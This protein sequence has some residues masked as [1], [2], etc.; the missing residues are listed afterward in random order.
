MKYVYS[1]DEGN[2]D[3]KELL[4]GKGANLS[5]MK[6]MKIPVPPGFIITTKACEI[7]YKNKKRLPEE[8]KKEIKRHLNELEK[9]TGKEFGDRKNPLLVSVRSG[10]PVS[11]PGMLDTIL[12]IGLNDETVEGLAKAMRNERMALDS[13]KRLIQTYASTVFGIEDSEFQEIIEEI[14]RGKKVKRIGA[15]DIESLREIIER[16]KRLI[17]KEKGEFPQNVEEQLW[18]A[19]NAVFN[20]WNNER[21]IHYRKTNKIKDAIGTAVIIQ[22]IVFG[23]LERDSATGVYF[24][25]NPA[26]GKNEPFGEYI[27]NA[28]GDELVGGKKTPENIKKLKEKMP[29]VFKQLVSIGKK[30][31]NHYKDMQDI[32]FTIEKGKL[33]ILQTRSGKRTALAEVNIAVDL[34]KE[35]LIEKEEALLRVKADSL[36]GLLHKKLKEEDKALHKAIAKGLPASIGAATGEIAFDSKEAK[37]MKEKGKDV[38]LVRTETSPEDITGLSFAE[39]LLTKFGGMTSHAAVVARGI[40]KCIIVGCSDIEIDYNKKEMRI[41]NKIFKKGDTLT[42]DGSTGE[43]FEG[44]LTTTDS[45]LSGSIGTLLEW[46]DEFR[47]LEIRANADNPEDALKARQLGAEG[48][49]LCRTE[50]MFFKEDRIYAF[51]RMILAKSKKERKEALE[52]LLNLQKEDFFEIFK[53]MN[54]LPVVIR[55]LDP[56]L[57]E[58]LPKENEI[59]ENARIL[60]ITEEELRSRIESLKEDN[61][62]LGHRGCRLLITSPEITEM[63][64]EAIMEAAIK[65]N[66]KGI[67]NEIEI[68]IPFIADV[69]EFIII[70]KIIERT[71]KKVFKREGKEVRY[72]LGTMIELPRA[73]LNAK[74]IAKEADFFSFGTNDLTQMS[75]GFSRDDVS[76]FLPKYLDEGIL[77]EDPFKTIDKKGVGRLIKIA[78]DEGRNAKNSLILGVCGEH[79]AEQKSIEFFNS[80]KMDYISCSPYGVPSARLAAAQSSIKQNKRKR[81]KKIKH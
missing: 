31:E 55:L 44:R 35:G 40:G 62:M 66:K 79:G 67:K 16:F 11:M 73:A 3:M 29:K 5:E 60:S 53:A 51:R 41:G 23:N 65:A 39:G 25:R 63:Q 8:I 77:D 17:R 24:T 21:A 2:K 46:A 58:F 20:S 14:Q 34:A 19:I 30:L 80:I 36:S 59:D 61:P 64:T 74:D 32:E 22:Q 33:Y 28:Q 78:S 47:K 37:Q 27:L 52:E 75:F 69:N 81:N 45:E 9:N 43:V 6:S 70:K 26:T 56:P 18:Q 10:A 13:Y 50:H 57:H 12:N 76:G 72:K 7:Y 38:I 48:I 71:A 68:M 42:L 54:G 49:G 1:F 15:L 4:G